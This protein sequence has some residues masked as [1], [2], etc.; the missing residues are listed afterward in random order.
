MPN[1]RLS[2]AA[3]WL[4][5]VALVI[6]LVEQLAGVT[7]LLASPILM[8]AIAWLIAL[9][10]EPMFDWA[11]RIHIPRRWAVPIV[12]TALASMIVT[13]VIALIPIIYDQINRLLLALPTGLNIVWAALEN[14][15]HQLRA[16]GV[17]SDIQA[18][19]RIESLLSQFGNLGSAALQQSL[20]LAGG[21]AQVLFEIIIV[22]ILSFY[23]AYDR[24]QLFERIV[25]VCPPDWRD[26]AEAFGNIIVQTFGGY[27]RAQIAI[28]LMYA[29]VN[30]VVMALL[31]IN[32]I[33][34]VTVIVSVLLLIPVVGGPIAL[35]PP[36]LIALIDAPDRIVIF[37]VIMLIVQQILF[38]VVVP[39]LIGRVVGLHPLL[40]FAALLIGSAVAGAWGILF[41]IPLAGVAAAITNYMSVR[42]EQPTG[43]PEQAT[44][45]PHTD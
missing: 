30:A 6:F 33:T 42:A 5:I 13:G 22:F 2:N 14:L 26:E 9:I 21:I 18:V 29:C 10:V 1:P 44:T 23:M 25:R 16:I 37:V 39:R 31:G 15:Q 34:L 27:M 41:G 36:V 43:T 20:E 8:F 12:Y 11:E 7:A 17:Q 35:I 24:A 28:S 4:I 3:L 19:I 45:A 38:N 32:S 40:V